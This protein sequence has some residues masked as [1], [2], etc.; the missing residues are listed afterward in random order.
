VLGPRRAAPIPD[1]PTSTEA[2][3]PDVQGITFNGVF[4]PKA[5]PGDAVGK[6]STTI[7]RVLENPEVV[8]KLA[9]LGSEARGS[10]PE[11]FAKF[12]QQESAKWAD[13][14]QKANIKVQGE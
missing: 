11:D 14:T 12:L 2:G 6:L 5:T 9:A 1:V 7:R 4:A 3:F 10:T 13:V 8:Q